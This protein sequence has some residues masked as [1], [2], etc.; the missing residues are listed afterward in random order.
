V[1]SVDRSWIP[2]GIDV[3]R[4]NPAR[5]YDAHLGGLHNF[6]A[7]RWSAQRGAD[8]DPRSPLAA[9]ANRAF[10]QRAVRHLLAAG[11]RQFIDLGPGIP[12]AGH[13]HEMAHA[14]DPSIPVLYID[15]DPVAVAHG[16]AIL[17]GIESAAMVEAD[18]RNV[19][20]VLAT[21]PFRRLIDRSRPVGIVAVDILQMI[22]DADDP[23]QLLSR[24][25]DFVSP[26]SRIVVSHPVIDGRD[27]EA[28]NGAGKA[29]TRDAIAE[30]LVGWDLVPPGLVPIAQWYADDRQGPADDGQRIAYLAA[31]AVKT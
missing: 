12:T 9:L 19:P 31:T 23:A 20:S 14:V 7:D 3:N 25:R 13:V 30:L 8:N 18:L 6:P 1:R 28:G 17:D 2:G 24:Y 27:T 10:L 21:P 26:A 16:Q 11:V 5:V 22:V 4:P 29:R 15:V